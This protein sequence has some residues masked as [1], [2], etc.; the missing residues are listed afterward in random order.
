MQWTS[1]ARSYAKTR[2]TSMIQLL[3][4]THVNNNHLYDNVLDLLILNKFLLEFYW[5]LHDKA[6]YCNALEQVNPSLTA[7][8]SQHSTYR[9]YAILALQGWM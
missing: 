5:L 7:S 1:V 8:H 3:F 2:T 9:R 6:D 4:G